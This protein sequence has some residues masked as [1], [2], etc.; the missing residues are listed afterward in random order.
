LEEKADISPPLHPKKSLYWVHKR[1]QVIYRNDWLG[2][3]TAPNPKSIVP[4]HLLRL[5]ARP[6]GAEIVDTRMHQRY[7]E[8]ELVFW[9]ILR[10]CGV[11]AAILPDAGVVFVFRRC[12]SAVLAAFVGWMLL[13]AAASTACA[14]CGDWLQHGDQSALPSQQSKDTSEA[15]LGIADRFP[16]PPCNGPSCSRV[17]EQPVAPA[18]AD[19]SVAPAKSALQIGQIT[20]AEYA[21]Q[22]R[23]T[24]EAGAKRAKGFPALVYHPPRA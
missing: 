7:A 11:P 18:P 4:Q 16:A 9:F 14:S 19:I 8:I 2:R 23:I 17:P 1:L 20:L 3:R 24:G 15:R 21:R 13:I 12:T 10:L 5:Q 22:S 6:W